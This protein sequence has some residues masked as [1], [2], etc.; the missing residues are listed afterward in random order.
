MEAIRL[1]DNGQVETLI[2]LI[3]NNAS[4]EEILDFLGTNFPPS[5]SAVSDEEAQSKASSRQLTPLARQTRTSTAAYRSWSAGFAVPAKPWTSVTDDDTLVSH[6]ISLWF[7]WRHWC[8]PFI[9]RDAFI[10]AMQ[11]GDEDSQVCTSFLVNMILA[12]A[13]VS[14]RAWKHMDNLD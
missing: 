9:E 12:D 3:R 4:Q 2:G 8:H 1:G 13:C 11:S 10:R 6:L 7:T 14:H 5:S